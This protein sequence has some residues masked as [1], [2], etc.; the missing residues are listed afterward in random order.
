MRMHHWA[1]RTSN[2]ERL[3]TFY[4]SVFGLRVLRRGPGPGG[5]VWLDAEGLVVMLERSSEGEPAVPTGTMEL[6]A[7]AADPNEPGWKDHWR[8]RIE[9]AGARIEAETPQTLYFR[10]PDGRRLACSVYPLR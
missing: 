1:L 8:A 7:F 2:L 3:E 5:S 10:D 9:L 4:I 6:M